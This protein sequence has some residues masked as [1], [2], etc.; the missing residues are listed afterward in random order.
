MSWDKSTFFIVIAGIL[1]VSLFVAGCTESSATEAAAE[2]VTPT[3]NPTEIATETPLVTPSEEIPESEPEPT[4]EPTPEAKAYDLELEVIKT[5]KYESLGKFNPKPDM[6]FLVVVFEITNNG[7]IPFEYHSGLVAVEDE[8]GGRWGFLK[9]VTF[10]QGL[11]PSPMYMRTIEP[12]MS[13]AGGLVFGV[14]ESSSTYRLLLADEEGTS[15]V[16]ATPIGT[17]S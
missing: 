7:D 15:I 1:M 9:E 3:V 14:P 11:L 16:A 6:I 12:G 10:D 17:V 8:D 4:V 13:A 5:G 2:T